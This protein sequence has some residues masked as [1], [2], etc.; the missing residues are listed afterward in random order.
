MAMAWRCVVMECWYGRN[1]N[2]CQV[3][4]LGFTV[5]R[6]SLRM[7]RAE[8]APPSPTPSTIPGRPGCGVM[9]ETWWTP[10][11]VSHKQN[12]RVVV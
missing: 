8:K 12:N 7:Q 6:P 5:V 10:C 3:A 9:T 2:L 1:V 11:G 4:Q